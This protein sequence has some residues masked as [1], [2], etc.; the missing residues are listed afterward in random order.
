LISGAGDTSREPSNPNDAGLLGVPSAPAQ[1]LFPQVGEYGLTQ[2]QP[3]VTA[4]AL[5]PQAM[6]MVPSSPPSHV[7][8]GPPSNP[9]S[10]PVEDDFAQATI[11]PAI[12]HITCT[13]VPP[14]HL[15][16]PSARAVSTR[17]T[18]SEC[19]SAALPAPSPANTMVPVAPIA[20]HL[21]GVSVSALG[22]PSA[23][24]VNEAAL[25]PTEVNVAQHTRALEAAEVGV[26]APTQ[27]VGRFNV[28]KHQDTVGTSENG[29][30]QTGGSVYFCSM[31]Y[32][33]QL[34][35]ICA[36]SFG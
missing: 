14:P 9:C 33:L 19:G 22:V 27:K 21:S 25:P 7:P 32:C 20:T 24:S 36:C 8:S 2:L 29:S 34:Q 6:P 16:Q 26:A 18:G 15:G 5:A 28:K 17:T 10:E 3:A 1:P 4:P 12:A 11:G 35:H 23:A 31:S 13:Y 30:A